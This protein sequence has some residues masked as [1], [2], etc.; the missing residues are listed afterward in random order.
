MTLLLEAPASSPPWMPTRY[1]LPLA[2]DFTTHGDWLLRLVDVV[3]RLPDGSA[4]EL[5]EWQRWLI[6]AMLETYPAGHKRA[7]ELRYRQVL[8]SVSR[9]NGKSVLGAILGLYGLVRE[10]GALVIGIASSA[11]QAR[12][13]Y[14]RLL[15]VIR[16]NKSLAARFARLTD[17]RG[18]QSLDGGRYEIKPSK[19]AAVQGLDLTVGLVDELHITKPELWSDMVNGSAARRSGVV[20]GLTTAGDDSSELLLQLYKNAEDPGARFGFFIW[21]APEARIPE[22]DETLGA[23]LCAA[24]PGLACG[25]LDL[26]TA[27][28]DVRGLPE[29]DAIRYRLN[30]FTAS[31]NAFITLDL[32]SKQRR[33]SGQ[34]F[35][36]GRPIFT[37]DRTPDWGFAAI[38]A[39]VKAGPDT[40]SELVASITNPNLEQLVAV[41]VELNRFSPV[42]FAMDGYALKDLGLEL[43]KRGLPV[44]IANQGDVI[45]ASALLYAKLSTGKLWHAGDPLLTLQVPRTVRKNIGEQFR[46]SRGDSSIEIDGV[47]STAIGVLAAETRSDDTL[48]VF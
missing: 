6:R 20:I 47:L 46:I 24:S 48:Q 18:I 1:S 43:K 9:Q 30:R 21:E 12:I 22:D 11:E 31:S 42:V 32:W 26:E 36:S 8:V 2:E 15:S 39:T 25:R 27:I 4:L 44:W 40:H 28:S 7:G 16:G 17:T 5:D 19:S 29:P 13:I 33:P 14:A 23:Y 45:N 37:F 3:W 10:A 41:A 38:T 35:P 34:A